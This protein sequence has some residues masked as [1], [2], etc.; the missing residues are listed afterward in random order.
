MAEG[1]MCA[2]CGTG[3]YTNIGVHNKSKKH[4]D[5]VERQSKIRELP[6]ILLE[7]VEAKDKSSQDRAKMVRR[8]FRELGWPCD[9]HTGTVKDFLDE[10][11]IPYVLNKPRK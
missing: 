4:Q 5:N 9:T 7:P 6:A 8:A 1:T 2:I 3:P 11:S 10:Y